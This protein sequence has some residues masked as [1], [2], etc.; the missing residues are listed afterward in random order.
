METKDGIK[1]YK[2]I[3]VHAGLER[4]KD[5]QEQLNSLK[6][7]DSKVPKI[8]CLSGRKNVWD[9]PNVRT[10]NSYTYQLCCSFNETEFKLNSSLG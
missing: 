2:L 8:E 7:K 6:A 9:I 4:G 10:Q 3:A 5:V 1:H